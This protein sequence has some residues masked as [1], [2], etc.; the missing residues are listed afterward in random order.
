MSSASSPCLPLRGVKVLDLSRVLAGPL[1]AAMLADLGADV[2][3]IERPDGGDDS[4]S[5]GPYLNGESTYFMLLNRG[6]KS[7]TLDLKKDDG[8]AIF[9]KL[10][11]NSDILVENFRPGVTSR[12]GIDYESLHAINPG[13]VYV[14]ISGF[15]QEGPLAQR[16]AYDHVIQAIGGIM[17]STGWPSTGPTRVGDPI[18]DVVSGLYGAWGALAGILQ[19]QISGK[20]THVDIAMLDAVISLQVVSL[21]RLMGGDPPPGLLGNA[22]AISAPMDTFPTVDGEIVI[23]VANDSLFTRLAKAIGQPELDQDFRF[24]SDAQRYQHQDA[25]K[26]ILSAW[27]SH[28]TTAEATSTLVTAGIPAAPVNNLAE[29]LESPH[30]QK[31]GVVK[32]VNHPVAGPTQIIPQ[33]VRFNGLNPAPD[34]A[35]PVLGAD[36][37]AILHDELELSDTQIAQLRS[38]H[39]I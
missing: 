33:P 22:H 12:L 24:S 7:I 25:L 2:T 4:R 10:V 32:Q 13:L 29:A 30:V 27:S 1:C 6:K 14:S 36:T 18:A 11:K 17:S 26:A 5:F 34:L 19:R 9:H 16:A 3:K 8:M 23:A 39:V 35:A 15:G 20:G 37:D 31:R 38:D 21:A 28:L